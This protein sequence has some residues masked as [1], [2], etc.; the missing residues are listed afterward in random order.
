MAEP[1][2]GRR[3]E[4]ADPFPWVVTLLSLA[5]GITIYFRSTAPALAEDRALR[6]VE[7]R[8][9]D[10][11]DRTAAEAIELRRRRER[12]TKDP[13]TVLVEL[14]R[15]G[16]DASALPAEPTEPATKR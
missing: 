3:A 7:E 4:R 10:S 11:A 13:E 5:V 1:A 16:L 2:R 8:L 9:R 15:H 12:L 14:D 6:E